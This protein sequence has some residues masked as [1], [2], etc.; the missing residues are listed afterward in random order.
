MKIRSAI[1]TS[2]F[3]ALFCLPLSG[4]AA[5]IE[6]IPVSWKANT[7][8]VQGWY[9]TGFDDASWS[10]VEV[11]NNRSLY[12]P[13]LPKYQNARYLWRTELLV[14]GDLSY[15]DVFFDLGEDTYVMALYVNG[16]YLGQSWSHYDPQFLGFYN[17]GVAEVTNYLT[18]GKNVIAFRLGTAS[19][20]WINSVKVRLIPEP[21]TIWL[22]L[23]SLP[24]LAFA[25][26]RRRE[27]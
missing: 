1:S 24:F 15:A 25:L 2:L 18:P 3:A 12:D 5:E 4:A 9:E 17:G 22:F 19:P 6:T 26:K 8:N 16:A 20:Y 21:S 27:I 10:D 14:C 7:Q 11:L 23:L 13:D